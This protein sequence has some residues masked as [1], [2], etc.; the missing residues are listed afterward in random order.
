MSL[1]T[2]LK[3]VAG[4]VVLAVVVF[5]A[6]MVRH[7]RE[8]PISGWFSEVV[9]V[10]V[11]ARPMTRLPEPSADLPEID[12]GA[13]VF[14]KA[15]ELIAVGDLAGAREKLR[16]VISI[17]PRSKA[18]PEAR[19]IVG[20]M[21]LD[22]V[23]SAGRMEGKQVHQVQRGDSYLGIAGKYDTSL[24]MILHLNGLMGLRALQPGDEVLVLPLRFRLVIE[25]KLGS[26]SVWD[27]GRFLKEYPILRLEGVPGGDHATSIAGKAAVSGGRRVRPESSA[28]R[29]AEKVLT[30]ERLP[31]VIAALPAA[32]GDEDEGLAR[33]IYLARED[34]EE[35]ALLIRPGN[36]VE[37]RSGGG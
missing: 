10:A 13:K 6:M 25:P 37:I 32:T 28:Y 8:Q 9:P 26:L 31:L 14:E 33:G 23:L 22:E 34:M 7:V 21:N 24:D 15:R 17:Y 3:I 18:A 36:R 5:T 2:L 1:L 29:G 12:P 27:E 19:R 35:L 11:E 4:L 20:E 30:L 16:T